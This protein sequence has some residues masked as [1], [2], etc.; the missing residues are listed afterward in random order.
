MSAT[1]TCAAGYDIETTGVTLG[2]DRLVSDGSGLGFT[3]SYVG[4][5]AFLTN[6]GKVTVDGWA[7]ARLRHV[8][9]RQRLS[10]RLDWFGYDKY[11]TRRAAVSGNA[12]GTT[13]GPEMDGY[14]GAA[15]D[16]KCKRFT[17]GPVA[18]VQYVYV[19][20]HSYDESGSLSPLHLEYNDA[21][22]L[23]SFAGARIA[24]DLPV[25]DVTLRPQI[26]AGWQHEFFDADH[27]ITS[28]FASG[29]GSDFTVHSSTIGRDSLSLSGGL[30]VQWSRAVSTYVCTTTANWRA[31]TRRRT[32]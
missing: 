14:P 3:A 30:S 19:G 13:D 15:Y 17:F 10:E 25:K 6:N 27:A 5:R 23:Q 22:S 29:A 21:N 11:D 4:N 32:R 31:K 8:V 18:S 1:E 12:S 16:F 7:G 24:Y 9:W 20:I 2:A 28:R 26:K